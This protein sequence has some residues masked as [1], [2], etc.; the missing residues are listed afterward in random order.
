MPCQLEIWPDIYEAH[1]TLY[2]CS[3]HCVSADWHYEENV[4]DKLFSQSM[5]ST[6]AL[7]VITHYAPP[8]EGFWTNPLVIVGEHPCLSQSG[9]KA[10]S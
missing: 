4:A 5:R 3:E 8:L 1:E 2:L 9:Y 6:T 10:Y 7:A